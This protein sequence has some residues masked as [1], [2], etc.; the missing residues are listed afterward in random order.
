MTATSKASTKNTGDIMLRVLFAA[1]ICGIAMMFLKAYL[2]SHGME[3]V[4]GWI[5]WL[6]MQDI[7]SKGANT[8]IGLFY[9]LQTLFL[10]GIQ[11]VIVPLVLSSIALSVCSLTDTVKLGRIAYKTV[12]GFLMFYVLGCLLAVIASKFAIAN[13]LFDADFSNMTADTSNVMELTVANPLNIIVKCVPNN[14]LAPMQINSA[15][16]AVI[17][18]SVGIGIA[19]NTCRDKLSGTKH[20]LEEV[21]LIITKWLEFLINKCGP[22]CIFAMI[23]RTF[24][25][26]SWEQITPFLHYMWITCVVLVVYWFLAYPS[27]VAFYCKVSPLKFFK[28]T[29][30]FGMF[31]LS[32][33]SSAATLPLNRKACIEDL[34]CSEAVADFVLPMGMTVNM[35]GTSIMHVIATAFIATAA[36]VPITFVAY[37][38]I[39]LL[40]IGSAAGTPAIPNGGSVMLYATMTGAGFASELCIMIYII[41]LTLNRPVDMLVTSLNVVGDAATTCIVSAS[42]GDLDR[43]VF[44][45]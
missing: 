34:G 14:F 37:L 1:I 19:I 25:I 44:N 3:N 12:L 35:N 23:V 32:V 9:I 11:L 45:S 8:A 29:F 31:A 13:G 43:A 5:N 15:I 22:I 26:Y 30:G 18:M 2:L 36:G 10:N 16:L 33:N 24:S 39:M 41:L 20:F 6:F 27:I 7:T 4:W 17:F 42:E 21:L 28:K 38:T 40:A